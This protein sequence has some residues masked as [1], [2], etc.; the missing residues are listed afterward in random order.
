MS[1]EPVPSMT[2]DEINELAIRIACGEIYAADNFGDPDF[3]MQWLVLTLALSDQL[4][5]NVGLVYE[6][7]AKASPTGINGKPIF[8][9]C[10]LLAVE[11]RQ[12]LGWAIA[13]KV[14]ALESA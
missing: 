6:E 12:R 5:P 10:Q 2:D 14:Q 11:D 9:S 4:P 8:F 3:A 13:R 7:I 1:A